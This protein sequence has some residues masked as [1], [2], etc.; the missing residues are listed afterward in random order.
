MNNIKSYS[1]VSI[2]LLLFC[3][4][5][6]KE[7]LNTAPTDQ[8]DQSAVFSTTSNA[9]IALNGIHRRMWTQ[10]FNQD[11][12]GQGSVQIYMDV[13]GEDLINN[14]TATGA[15]YNQ[16]YR[17][18]A[19]RNANSSVPYFVYHFYYYIISSAN[20]LINNIDK[21]SG[22]ESDKKIIKGQ[23]LAYRAWAHF[24]L[25]QL[26]GKR[27]DAAAKPN[28]QSGVPLML[29]NTTTGQPRATV[30]EVYT[31]VN[32]DLDDAITNLAGYNRPAKSHININVAKGIKARVALTMQDWANAAKFASEAR[33]GFTLMSKDQY[34]AGFNDASN[35]EWM[36]ASIVTTDQGTFFYSY[37]A[38][39]SSN[40][41]S[42]ATRTNPRSINKNLYDAIPATD[43]RKQ[44]W[45]PAGVTPPANG[46]KF[47]YTGTKFRVKDPT[48]SVGDV[49]YMRAAEMYL[50][51]AEANARLSKNTEAQDLLL[52]L[53]KSRDPDYVKPT[54]TGQALI[55]EISLQRRIELWGE[56]FRFLDLKR[57]NSPLDR[58]GANHNAAI[59]V[60]LTV[61]AGDVQWEWLFPQDEINANP[62][63]VQNPL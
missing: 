20:A 60:T 52:T 4:S 37:F 26:F 14:S 57:T 5:C 29:T 39:M 27:Y 35:P 56:G 31:Q 61:P 42:N 34:L 11:E 41:S 46:T 6:K 13:L 40:F 17:W 10:Y 15:F 25:V 22:P 8:I 18:Q 23:A 62:A 44:L 63:I 33:Q 59:A 45:N 32:K 24:M 53:V 9:M 3:T 30:E 38:Y 12:A 21:A 7:W 54:K 43:V 19:H 28:N 50:I 48:V 47:P 58:T 55:D 16:A 36:W 2:M 49:V 51:E 1:L